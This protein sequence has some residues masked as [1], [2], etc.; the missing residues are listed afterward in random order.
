[1]LRPPYD[2]K[3]L[4]RALAVEL[5]A[6]RALLAP[7]LENLRQCQVELR[8]QG[9]LADEPYRILFASAKERFRSDCLAQCEGGDPG[10]ISLADLI[11]LY[12][13]R[14]CSKSG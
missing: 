7:A 14:C 8:E 12:P 13:D 9:F 3:E 1:M 11:E 10:R 2:R 4:E 5:Q 6:V